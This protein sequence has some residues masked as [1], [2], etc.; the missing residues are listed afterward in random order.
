[1]KKKKLIISI[2]VLFLVLIG[3]YLYVNKHR[4]I[5]SEEGSFT[6]SAKDI[7]LGIGTNESAANAKYLDKTIE[8]S[9]KISSIDFGTRSMVINEKIFTCFQTKF[10][11]TFSLIPK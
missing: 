9:G 1:M 10:P 11:K 7:F 6:V 3:I 8:V 2:L 4:N 5:A